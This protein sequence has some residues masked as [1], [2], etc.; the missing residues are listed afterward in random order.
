LS[1]NG[2]P[3]TEVTRTAAGELHHELPVFLP[4]GRHFLYFRHTR[5][6]EQVGI[7]IGDL[8]APPSDQPQT[9]LLAA[10]DGLLYLE[11]P[12]G[13]DGFVLF[14]QRGTLHAQ[15]FD[16]G[17]LPLRGS[18][19]DIAADVSGGGVDGRLSAARSG[20]LIVYG[21]GVYQSWAGGE[22][23]LGRSVRTRDAAAASPS[24]LSIPT[25]L[26]RRKASR[27]CSG[28]RAARR[29]R[30]VGLQRR[31]RR[32]ASP[33]ARRETAYRSGPAK[34]NGSFSARRCIGHPTPV[35]RGNGEISTRSART[36]AA[37]SSG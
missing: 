29:D 4:D 22:S 10:D 3:P 34:A 25:Y 11:D 33:D 16:A 13:G 8:N 2:G 27:D 37:K 20:S 14:A 9:R 28:S 5:D 21:T 26:S 18:P 35:R 17:G 23:G 12:K 30:S 15:R 36:A 31:D 1:A 32:G 6:P 24:Q 19:F 7:F